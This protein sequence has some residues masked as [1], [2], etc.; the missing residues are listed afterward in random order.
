MPGTGVGTGRPRGRGRAQPDLPGRAA[1]PLAIVVG[2]GDPGRRRGRGR[3]GRRR[4][5]EAHGDRVPHLRTDAR[6]RLRGLQRGAGPRA[7]A[8]SLGRLDHDGSG[9]LQRTARLR[10][11][12][13]DRQQQLQRHVRA[14]PCAVRDR[15]SRRGQDAGP[16][17]T[18]R[19]VGL[20]QPAADQRRA[21]RDRDVDEDVRGL[22]IGSR[23]QR[24]GRRSASDGSVR[25]VPC[26]GHR[27][28]RL[29]VPGRDHSLVRRL[30]D[31]G[32]RPFSAAEDDIGIH[33]PREASPRGGRRRR[34]QEL[35]QVSRHRYL[36]EREHSRGAGGRLHPPAGGRLVAAGR[37]GRPGWGGR[38]RAGAEPDPPGGERRV[39][40]PPGPRVGAAG[41]GGAR[42]GGDIG[43][44]LG[45][46]RWS[47]GP[48]LRALPSRSGG[49]GAPR[50]ALDRPAFS[51]LRS[52]W[53]VRSPPWPS[54]SHWESG[55]RS[56]PHAVGGT[57]PGVP[58]R[59][60]LSG[61]RSSA[62]AWLIWT[63]R[64]R[65]SETPTR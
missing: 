28:G 35:R 44:R 5:R 63:P 21:R 31:T 11:Y 55:L 18:R 26:R 50:R 37:P 34:L 24:H 15:Q 65:S 41:P 43:R 40:G 14:A 64:H 4:R 13:P 52:C 23:Q 9:R 33:L 51:M 57:S 19:G 17:I 47:I 20:L 56:V 10:L 7:R 53:G 32:L 25:L 54:S 58:V 12:A 2:A 1:P 29:R 6:L 36:H 45:W 59:R 8:V 60:P 3:H 16:V 46:R 38:R 30:H 42:D 61:P 49:R 39:P 27:S 48:G 22:P 62:R